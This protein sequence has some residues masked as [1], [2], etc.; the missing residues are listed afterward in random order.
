M[1]REIEGEIIAPQSTK[2]KGPEPGIIKTNSFKKEIQI[3]VRQIQ[4]LHIE[5]KVPSRRNVN[6]LSSKAKFEILHY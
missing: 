4:K 1:N 6:P 2:R 5:K 3:V